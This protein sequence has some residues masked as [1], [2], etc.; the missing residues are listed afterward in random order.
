MSDSSA[1]EIP[2]CDLE[3]GRNAGTI[4]VRIP[5]ESLPGDTVNF[6]W[7]GDQ[8]CCTIPVGVKPRNRFTALVHVHSTVHASKNV[9]KQR[10]SDCITDEAIHPTG[11][12][13]VGA[14]EDTVTAADAASTPGSPSKASPVP[15][16]SLTVQTGRSTYPINDAA[17]A[18]GVYDEAE[19][20]NNRASIS[21]PALAKLYRDDLNETDSKCELT[22]IAA[23]SAK[24]HSGN[25]KT[26]STAELKWK[27]FPRDKTLTYRVMRAVGLR[28]PIR[29]SQ[30]L[31]FVDFDLTLCAEHTYQRSIVEGVRGMKRMPLAEIRRMFGG[32]ERIE[33]LKMFFTNLVA[34]GVATVVVTYGL[35][36]LVFIMLARMGLMGPSDTDATTLAHGILA[37]CGSKREGIFFR[38]DVC[39]NQVS[40][41]IAGTKPKCLKRV[42]FADDTGKHIAAV[43][44]GCG[45]TSSQVCCPRNG[46]SDAQLEGICHFFHATIPKLVQRF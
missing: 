35:P 30:R 13:K 11:K 43:I 20:C 4:K 29:K 8:Y 28:G 23:A 12:V 31:F 1:T 7:K 25:T 32:G 34:V 44:D 6:V 33:L 5:E 27:L 15:S 3:I 37:V 42:F 24:L 39:I 19:A 22:H 21:A 18:A 16:S 9:K 26:K 14:A 40:N 46:L 2:T 36:E 38:K 17:L 10:L 45:L 41:A